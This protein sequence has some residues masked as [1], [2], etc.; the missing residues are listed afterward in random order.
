MKGDIAQDNEQAK[1]QDEEILFEITSPLNYRRPKPFEGLS[2]Y[3]Q[4]TSDTY[5]DLLEDQEICMFN[6]QMGM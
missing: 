4:R 6:K 3:Y 1:M 5:E 2:S